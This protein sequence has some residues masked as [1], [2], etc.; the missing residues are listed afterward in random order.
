MKVRHDTGFE[1][2]AIHAGHVPDPMTGAVMPPVYQTSTYV[3]DG[4]AEPRGG[5]VYA[6]V[7]NPT[8]TA[9]EEN[10]A[11]L[12]GGSVGAAFASGLAAIESLLKALLKEGDHVVCGA[13]V[14]GGTE[15]M[16]RTVWARFGLRFTY[17][18]TSDTEALAAAIRPETRLVHIETPTNPMMQISD[19]AAC[20]EIAHKGDALLSVDNTFPTPF[21]QRPLAMG[22]DIVVHST[23]KYLNG[24]SDVIGGAI[25]TRDAELGARIRDQQRISGAVPGPLDCWLVLRGIKTLHV[26]MERHCENARQ[27]ADVLVGHVG[28]RAVLYP[29][30]ATHPQHQLASRQMGGFGGMI[31][32]DAGSLDRARAVAGSTRIFQLAE[33]LG[34]VESLISVPAVMT[35]AS[36]PEEVRRK[37]GLTDG[38]VRLSVGIESA[39][40]LISDL[41]Q[42]LGK[43]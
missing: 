17:V 29:G 18:D 38:L 41:E 15:R 2:L 37:I 1:T 25:V 16:F 39:D 31:S 14:Y 20:A 24:H 35:H 36:V 32:F 6:R 3:Q 27:L 5:H 28:H 26:R 33:S 42:A 23:T 19:I 30:L 10:L 11:A 8:R 21:L 13:N 40:D 22:A 9:L 4:V 12:E 7:T 34:G 43:A